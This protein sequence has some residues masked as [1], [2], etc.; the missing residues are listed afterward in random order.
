MIEK[1]RKNLPVP[2]LV[3]ENSDGN[4]TGILPATHQPTRYYH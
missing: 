3:S 1:K 4:G 2:Y